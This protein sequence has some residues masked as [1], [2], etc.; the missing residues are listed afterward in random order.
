MINVC[1]C[2][3]SIYIHVYKCMVR[4]KHFIF[5]KHSKLFIFFQFW[6]IRPHSSNQKGSMFWFVRSKGLNLLV[7][8]LRQPSLS[9]ILVVPLGNCQCMVYLSLLNYYV[10]ISATYTIL[11]I[12]LILLIVINVNVL[13]CL[14]CNIKI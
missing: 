8:N 3:H 1:L 12:L 4:R 14:L 9:L 7:I 13:I 10:T 2:F 6:F 5:H 11:L